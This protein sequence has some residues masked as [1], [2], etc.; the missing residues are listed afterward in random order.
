MGYRMI[1]IARRLEIDDEVGS[2]HREFLS[3][4]GYAPGR[5]GTRTRSR[6]ALRLGGLRRVAD[7]ATR[8]PSRDR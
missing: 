2:V 7:R 3:P 6:T 8:E 4:R 5:S 1:A